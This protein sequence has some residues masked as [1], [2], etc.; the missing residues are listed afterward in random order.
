MGCGRV[1]STLA[2]SLEDRDHSVAVIDSNP[3]AFRRLGPSFNGTKVTGI[4]ELGIDDA[5]DQVVTVISH[6]NPHWARFRSPQF[7]VGNEILRTLGI[8]R[9]DRAEFR[10]ESVTGN[11]FSI[12]LVA[13]PI[14]EVSTVLYAPVEET[15]DTPLHLRNPGLNYW[16][17]WI[18]ERRLIY[19]KYNVCRDSPTEDFAAFTKRLFTLAD[20][21]RPEKLVVD[22]RNNSG[23]SSAV[24]NP[25]IDAIRARSWLDQPDRLF[26]ITGP[27]T[28]SSAVLK[29]L[30][31]RRSTRAT[32]VGE[33]T[34]GNA[35]VYGEVRSFVLPKRRVTVWH[36]S[37]YF[38]IDA[39]NPGAV[40][41]DIHIETSSEDYF[42]NRDP[43]L[44]G[45][46]TGTNQTLSGDETAPRRH[47]AVARRPPPRVCR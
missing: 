41:P 16:F 25:L 14:A 43:V 7:L 29:A 20:R 18:P 9:E 21:E 10:F 3:D 42:S 39:S 11:E 22:M 30:T 27:Q 34:G 32:L 45:I 26:V 37:K 23:G 6:D 19:V 33:P 24:I 35:N 28:F 38:D 8:N 36:S 47:R 40:V 44:E 17:A 46:L 15:G 12:P 2:R 5:Y 31:F 4:D 13:A 1:G